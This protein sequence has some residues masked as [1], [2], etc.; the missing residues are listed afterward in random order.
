MGTLGRLDD[1]LFI[2][3]GLACSAGLI[4][5]EAAFQ[6]LDESALYAVFFALLAPAQFGWAIALY[7]FPRRWLLVAGAAVNLSIVCV[8]I[9]SRTSGMPIGPSPWTPESVGAIDMI[10]TL[11]EVAIGLL[12]VLHLRPSGRAARIVRHP[13]TVFALTLLIVSSMAL[14]LPSH[15]H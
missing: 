7:K 6:H 13:A 10:A 14:M 8:W 2:V 5:V 4:H 11:D 15:E 3:C 12:V 9:M 1:R